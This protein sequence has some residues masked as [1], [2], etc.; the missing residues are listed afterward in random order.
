MSHYLKINEA[1]KM[2]QWRNEATTYLNDIGIRVFNPAKFFITNSSYN[3]IGILPQNKHYVK[4]DCGMALAS[5]EYLEESGGSVWELGAFSIQDKPIIAFGETK[6]KDVA[7]I[8]DSISMHFN[9]LQ[10][11]LEYIESMYVQ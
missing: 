4:N 3:S 6:W 8:R 9:T 2:H 11:A 5:L 1:D 10:E 7:H